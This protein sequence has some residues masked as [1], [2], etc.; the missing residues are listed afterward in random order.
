[1]DVYR[2]EEEQ[3]E[4]LKKWWDE[5]A[6]SI[7]AGIVI[8]L[9]VVFG[10]RTWQEHRATQAEA[11][12][13]AYQQLLVQLDGGEAAAV[14]EQGKQLIA[15]HPN[16]VYAVLAALALAQQ[17]VDQ[18]DA[19]GAAAQLRWAMANSKQP[20][21]QHMARVRLAR[22]LI[23]QGKAE[24]ALALLDNMA[25]S[26]Y[27]ALYEET[28]GDAHV[29]LGQ[30]AAA[31]QAYERALSGY[32]ESPPKQQLLRMKLDDLADAGGAAE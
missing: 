20:E 30:R 19:E 1:M 22:V 23:D 7:I 31:R 10:W 17:A 24:E 9:A 8:A 29:A 3:V 11:A 21:L 25:A 2:T 13:F 32:A 28:K 15:A 27:Q 26:A 18:N 4:A 16:S 5:N 12:S 14:S 6:R